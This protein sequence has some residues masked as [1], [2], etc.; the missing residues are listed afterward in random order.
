MISKAVETLSLLAE[1]MRCVQFLK[2]ANVVPFVLYAMDNH[3][4]NV[5]V[6]VQCS[7]VRCVFVCNSSEELS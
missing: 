7:A 5:Q 4:L 1:D 3:P 2:E 6:Q